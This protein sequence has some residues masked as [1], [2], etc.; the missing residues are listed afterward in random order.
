MQK[1]YIVASLN[2]PEYNREIFESNV[3]ANTLKTICQGDLYVVGNLWIQA[4]RSVLVGANFSLFPTVKAAKPG[5]A[6]PEKP[7][8]MKYKDLPI[9]E[10]PHYEYKDY[11]EDK[12]KNP[13]AN[14]KL[15]HQYLYPKVRSVRKEW[16]ES[17]LELKKDFGEIMSDACAHLNKKKKEF[18]KYMR[19]SENVAVRQAVVALGS[20]TG[21]Y[22]GSGR[23]IPRRLFYTSL[24]ALAAGAL[25]FPKETDEIFREVSYRAAKSVLA[26]YNTTCGKNITMRERIPC[27]RDMP[28]ISA[29]RPPGNK[30]PHNTP[31][32]AK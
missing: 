2:V 17:I 32:N 23:G 14:I 18:K 29:T 25:C 19:D 21:Y 27:P 5:D 4:L 3:E 31:V 22:A 1:A 8:P 24:G 26:L 28:Q 10:S 13:R 11:V 15:M 16:T 9:Y 6:A 30:C 12:K 20:V 7:P